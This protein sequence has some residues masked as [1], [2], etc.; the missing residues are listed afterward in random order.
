MTEGGG[1]GGGGGGAGLYSMGFT[2][3]L[4]LALVSGVCFE[5]RCDLNAV[6]MLR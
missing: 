6:L 3:L 5:G 2:S 1:G 4:T